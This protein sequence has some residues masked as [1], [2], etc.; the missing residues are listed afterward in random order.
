MVYPRPL[1]PVLAAFIITMRTPYLALKA[2]RHRIELELV[3]GI[4][5]LDALPIRS[6]DVNCVGHEKVRNITALFTLRPIP[7][8]DAE[9]VRCQPVAIDLVGRCPLGELL[10]FIIQHLLRIIS[11]YVDCCKLYDLLR[12]KLDMDD[13]SRE[14]RP[15]C[16]DS[17]QWSRFCPVYLVRLGVFYRACHGSL[18]DEDQL[19]SVNLGHELTSKTI[20]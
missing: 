2:L 19:L 7:V 13:A 9:R 17:S 16:G 4:I 3:Q 12:T 14:T 20:V 18:F 5:D 1:V 11:V 10:D 6:I 8:R 15:Y